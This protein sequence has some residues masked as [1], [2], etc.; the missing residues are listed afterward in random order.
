MSSKIKETTY[1]EKDKSLF[2]TNIHYKDYS[3]QGNQYKSYLHPT[4]A[5]TTRVIYINDLLEADK[6]VS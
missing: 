6:E 3:L 5:Y 2:I 4:I 1:K